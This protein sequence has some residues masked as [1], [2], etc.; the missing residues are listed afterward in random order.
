MRVFRAFLQVAVIGGL[1]SS[2]ALA[3]DFHD[4]QYGFS[5]TPPAFDG[6]PEGQS[7]VRLAVS[8]PA[9]NG[10]SP[11]V[12]VTVQSIKTTRDAFVE[13]SES[14]FKT[15]NFTIRSKQNRLVSGRPAV[16]FDYEGSFGGPTLR[17]LALAVVLPERVLLVTCTSLASSYSTHEREFKRSI[18]SSRSHA[19]HEWAA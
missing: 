4:T 6:L 11:N 16:L 17:F 3:T 13:L 12:N 10:F 9:Q 8:G 15:A 1:V 5:L 14:Q 7:V 19:N 18:N 2:A